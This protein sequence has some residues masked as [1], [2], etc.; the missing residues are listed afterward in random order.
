MNYENYI[1]KYPHKQLRYKYLLD[2]FPDTEERM[3][4]KYWD[5][6][7]KSAH[8]VRANLYKWGTVFASEPYELWLMGVLKKEGIPFEHD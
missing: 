4:E 8:F 3:Q 5:D 1:S 2:K 6:Y 7:R